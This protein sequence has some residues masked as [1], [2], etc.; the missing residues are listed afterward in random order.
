MSSARLS[1]QGIRAATADGKR[2]E[3][4]DSA[5]I[6]LTLRVTVNGVKTFAFRYRLGSETG[7]VTI[8]KYPTVSLADA[9]EIAGEYRKAVAA[10][11]PPQPFKPVGADD[12]GGQ[13][14]DEV[15]ARYIEEYAKPNKSS[16]QNDE[17]YLKRPRAAWGKRQIATITDDDVAALLS[18]IAKTAPVSANRTQ[19]VLHKM[20]VWAKEPGR[21]FVTVN[22]L[23]D[24]PRQGKESKTK[25][26]RVLSDDEIRTLWRGL[27]D[28][29]LPAGPSVCRALKVILATMARPGMVSGMEIE[30]LQNVG[31]RH[32]EWHLPPERMKSRRPFVVPLSRLAAGLI[33]ESLADD[34]QPVVF[35]SDR[36]EDGKVARHSLS[37]AT[38]KVCKYLGLAKFTPHDLRRTASTIARRAGAPREDVKALLDHTHADVTDVYDKYDMLAEKRAVVGIVERE[39]VRILRQS[40]KPERKVA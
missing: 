8:G 10:G 28:P 34:G 4:S 11:R 17:G 35:P 20:F 37:Q 21:K 23:A 2:L 16:W 27:E 25:Q 18:K 15:A 29:N 3:I 19:S 24:M 38:I 7:R 33:R 22:P 31:G 5:C 36:S 39:L 1:D 32:P 13:T 30:E 12:E 40:K 26:Q 9:R 14:F 6:G